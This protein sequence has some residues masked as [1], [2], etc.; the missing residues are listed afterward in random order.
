[1]ATDAS[2]VGIAAVLLQD[3]GGG[4]QPVSYWAHKLNPAERSN[5]FSAYDLENLAVCEAVKDILE[6]LS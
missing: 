4:L 2:T 3:Q 5:T 6:V 1:V